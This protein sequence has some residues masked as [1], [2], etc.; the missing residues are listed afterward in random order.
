MARSETRCRCVEMYGLGGVPSYI[1]FNSF[2]SAR[3]LTGPT[4]PIPPGLQCEQWSILSERSLVLFE[5][6]V[7]CWSQSRA[8]LRHQAFGISHSHSGPFGSGCGKRS[9]VM[10]MAL[11]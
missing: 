3:G 11:D 8:A 5:V 10:D 1:L 6:S 9:L 7:R 2:A 4:N